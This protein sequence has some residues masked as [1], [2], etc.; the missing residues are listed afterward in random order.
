MSEILVTEMPLLCAVHCWGLEQNQHN[1]F[2]AAG[3][4]GVQGVRPRGSFKLHFWLGERGPPT[5][6]PRPGLRQGEDPLFKNKCA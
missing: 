6:G 2:C 4:G 3:E 1:I 5:F